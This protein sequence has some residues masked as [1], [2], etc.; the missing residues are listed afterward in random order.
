V[1]GRPFWQGRRVLVTGHTGFTG[2]WLALHLHDLGARVAGYALAP[3]TE[4]SL[5]E[6]CRLDALVSSTVADIRDRGALAVAA[7]AADP[8]VIIHLAA[9]P[10]VRE[11]YRQP[12]ETWEVN[13]MGTVN[14]LE[15]A[16]ACRNLRAVVLVTSDKCYEN[17]EWV[18]GY[19]ET[20]RLGGADPYASSKA[21]AELAAAAWTSSFFPRVRHAEHGVALATA[22]A[23]NIVGG[24]DWAAERLAPDFFRAILAGERLLLRNPG[25]TRPWQHVLDPLEGYLLLAERLAERGAA[26]GGSWNFGPDQREVRTVEQV[27]RRLCAAWG[28]GAAYGVDAGSHPHE[29]RALTLD[30]AKARALLGWR[31]AW[32]FE[33]AIAET[34]A[35]VRDWQEGRDPRDICRDQIARHA[36]AL[37]ALPGPA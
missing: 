21:A 28:D 33:E 32:G 3:P 10:L 20:D 15:A 27:A 19:R 2:S 22:R 26:F 7:A 4:P 12:A 29:S 17:R 30:S 24:G 31:P 5:Y 11:S 6:L 13:V 8:E 16:R 14:L 37:A 34:T 25:A 1:A 9:Q 35:W 18:W 23:G 36:A